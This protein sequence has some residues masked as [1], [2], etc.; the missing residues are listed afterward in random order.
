MADGS[1]QRRFLYTVRDSSRPLFRLPMP[2]CV[3]MGAGA[4]GGMRQASILQ[5]AHTHGVCPP[6]LDDLLDLKEA[7]QV[8]QLE[9]A[10]D[11]Q[12]RHLKARIDLDPCVGALGRWR[13]GRPWVRRSVGTGYRRRMRGG[14]TLLSRCAR[15]RTRKYCWLSRME[16]RLCMVSAIS[17]SSAASSAV[18]DGIGP[19]GFR[20]SSTI[21]SKLTVLAVTVDM[22]FLKQ[23]SKRPLTSAANVYVSAFCRRPEN[24]TLRLGSIS[25]NATR[26]G[27]RAHGAPR[28][29]SGKGGTAA[30]AAPPRACLEINVQLAAAANLKLHA[31]LG[32]HL[33]RL[34]E[35]RGPA[36]RDDH[37][38]R[39]RRPNV[40]P[41]T[42]TAATKKAQHG[43]ST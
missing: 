12:Q 26:H 27:A 40:P 20:P 18:R 32:A 25:C 22:P 38:K 21:T 41:R 36:R 17:A 34:K 6:R 9:H 29:V 5:H 30:S 31:H 7:A 10:H 19:A 11:H 39:C 35:A 8:P 23:Y 28:V 16:R 15:S 13:P 33:Q 4:R 14:S 1:A 37:R 3:C 42:H 2:V 43:M 24:S